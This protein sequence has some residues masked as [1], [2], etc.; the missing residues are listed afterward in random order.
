MAK[1][2][3]SHIELGVKIYNLKKMIE[4]NNVYDFMG[5]CVKEQMEAEV[6]RLQKIYDEE[7]KAE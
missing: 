6:E 3:L 5:N 1:Y 4:E 7:E 2:S